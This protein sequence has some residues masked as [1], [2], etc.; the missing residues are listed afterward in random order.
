[1]TYCYDAVTRTANS[2][3]ENTKL[4]V[5]HPYSISYSQY[6]YYFT[7]F[8]IYL[9]YESPIKLVEIKVGGLWDYFLMQSIRKGASNYLQT[10]LLAY[11]VKASNNS[12]I[13]CNIL[14]YGKL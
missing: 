11:R 2:P 3:H 12:Y 13:L 4:C 7:S 6:I 1:M 5:E 10:R 8:T 14:L 9:F